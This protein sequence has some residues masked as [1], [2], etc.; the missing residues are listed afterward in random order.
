MQVTDWYSLSW[1]CRGGITICLVI[2]LIRGVAKE[3][4]SFTLITAKEIAH[5][6]PGKRFSLLRSRV[7]LDITGSSV[8]IRGVVFVL[9]GF[10]VSM[11]EVKQVHPEQVSRIMIQRGAASA[12]YDAEAM[13]GALEITTF[14]AGKESKHSLDLGVDS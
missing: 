2:W 6:Q 14:Q 5:M 4:G 3:E 7:G 1:F 12:K 13:G 10:T 11:G 9:D 8:T